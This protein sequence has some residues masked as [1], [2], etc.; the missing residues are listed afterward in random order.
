MFKVK[1]ERKQ[2]ME[3]LM[4]GQDGISH[5]SSTIEV[6]LLLSILERLESIDQRLAD[7]KPQ[8]EGK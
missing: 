5:E 6:N 3:V 8:E 1:F 2:H 7:T 4:T